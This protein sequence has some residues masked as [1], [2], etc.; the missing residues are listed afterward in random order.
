M[1]GSASQSTQTPQAAGYVGKAGRRIVLT[2]FGSLGDVHPYIAIA[3]GL[4]ERGHSVV[5]ATTELYREK[6]ESLGIGFAP[7]RPD[8]PE[9]SGD[10]EFMRKVMDLRHGSEFVV[11][12]LVMP[13]LRDSYDDVLAAAQGADL[14]VSHPLTFVTPLVAEKLGIRW[15]SSILAPLG[16]FSVY[17]PPVLPPAQWMKYLRPLGPMAWRPL[18]WLMRQMVRGWS[19]PYHRL[20][21]DLGLPPTK[22]EPLFEGQHSPHLTLAL[23]SPL[24]GMPQPDWPA[25]A[26]ATGFPFYD[27]HEEHT[28]LPAEL[29]QFLSAGEPPIVFTLGSSAVMDAGP[30]Y[31]YAAEAAGRLKRRAVLLVGKDERNRPKRPVEGVLA[32]EYAPYSELFSRAAA[33]VHQGGVGTTAQ[34]L[35]AGRP[36]LVMPYAHDQPDNADRCVRLGV[37]RTIARSRITPGRLEHTLRRLLDDC[38]YARCAAGVGEFVRSEDGVAKACD[39]LESYCSSTLSR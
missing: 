39:A 6:I 27:K 13:H 24:L 35:R 12:E 29:E 19:G 38:S 4:V 5:I 10:S 14:V 28:S 15:A 22:L 7:V 11:R 23:F 36:M 33:I 17:D 34:A 18:T 32:C 16:F 26:V 30:F 1:T 8:I 25:S 37:A 31:E 3:L 21:A 9:P 20:R 2:T